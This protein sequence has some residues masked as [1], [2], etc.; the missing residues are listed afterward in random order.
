MRNR[1]KKLRM[2]YKD[3]TKAEL[4]KEF[5][6]YL[7]SI[8]KIKNI[9]T[10]IHSLATEFAIDYIKAKIKKNKETIIDPIEIHPGPS[11]GK[12]IFIKTNKETHYA[13]VLC[14][15]SFKQNEEFKKLQK[16]MMKLQN[17]DA[18][19]KY[20]FILS[21]KQKEQAKERLRR[22]GNT[23]NGVEFLTIFRSKDGTV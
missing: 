16:D 17:V 20:L 7:I 8:K 4:T 3:K 2:H 12:D 1:E 11:K 21:K 6:E 22:V 19:K 23:L 18:T 10:K 13:E 14:N 9:N 5:L 15:D